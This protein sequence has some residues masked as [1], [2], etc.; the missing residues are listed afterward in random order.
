MNIPGEPESQNFGCEQRYRLSQQDKIQVKSNAQE[1][2]RKTTEKR[3]Q[4]T[5]HQTRDELS[6][7]CSELGPDNRYIESALRQKVLIL[8]S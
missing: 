8:V 5:H 3:R 2:M 4:F 6:G 7:P 1:I